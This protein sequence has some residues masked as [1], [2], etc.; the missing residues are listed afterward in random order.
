MQDRILEDLKAAMKAGDKQRLEVLR[1]VKSALQ[2]AEI[3]EKGSFDEAAQIKVVMKEAKKRREAAKM[4]EEGGNNDRAAVEMA[5][6]TI[7][8]EYLPEMMSEEEIAKV[9]DETIESV[10]VRNVGVIMG[11]VMGKLAGQADGSLVS[12]VVKEKIEND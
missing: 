9:V 8:E 3:D 11:Q 12:K 4:F 10:G 2:M 6:A 1:M 7:I 5:E